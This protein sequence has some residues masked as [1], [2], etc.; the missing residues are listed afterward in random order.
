MKFNNIMFT[1]SICPFEFF[2]TTQDRQILDI[3]SPNIEVYL[4]NYLYTIEL[5][6]ELS[7][8]SQS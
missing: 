1:A 4:I 3:S 6:L 7:G 2:W 8:Q 5:I